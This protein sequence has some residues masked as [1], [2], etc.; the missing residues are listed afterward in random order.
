MEN[1]SKQHDFELIVEQGGFR[2]FRVGKLLFVSFGDYNFKFN[3]EI[4]TFNRHIRVPVSFAVANRSSS[5]LVTLSGNKITSFA[6]GTLS[7][8][9]TTLFY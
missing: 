1:L 4:Y 6:N 8:M 7:G 2:A 5:G 9:G 3:T